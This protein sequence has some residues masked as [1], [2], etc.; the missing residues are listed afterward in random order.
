MFINTPIVHFF[1]VATQGN[2]FTSGKRVFTTAQSLRTTIGPFV[3][4]TDVV[5]RMERNTVGTDARLAVT[6]AGEL[7]NLDSPR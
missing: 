3:A 2:D 6:L 5:V 1:V 7:V 4:P